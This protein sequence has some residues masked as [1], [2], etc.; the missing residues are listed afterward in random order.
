[1]RIR[2][3]PRFA[4]VRPGTKPARP[5]RHEAPSVENLEGRMV[6]SG[7]AP[8]SALRGLAQHLQASI[9]AFSATDRAAPDGG[10]SDVLV[11]DARRLQGAYAA[12]DASFLKAASGRSG[13][14]AFDSALDSATQ[15]LDSAIVADLANLPRTG[16]A[17]TATLQADAA[18]LNATLKADAASSGGSLAPRGNSAILASFDHATSAIFADVPPG[19][20]PS[21]ALARYDASAAS[22]FATFRLAIRAIDKTALASVQP[23]DAPAVGQALSAY[24]TSLLSAATALG[25]AVTSRPD[26]PLPLIRAATDRSFSALTSIP[27]PRATTADPETPAQ[28][29]TDVKLATGD[30]NARM[31]E[32]VV[33]SVRSYNA[34]LL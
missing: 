13:L 16:P 24:R 11:Q 31:S 10:P 33:S 23:L 25:P 30:V 15:A 29:Q 28:F 34:G 9:R 2:V 19:Q 6:L 17:L 4:A 18:S 12:F 26:G 27:A 5:R 1:M 8:S 22:A 7:S 14:S 21:S 3:S 32:A 20:V